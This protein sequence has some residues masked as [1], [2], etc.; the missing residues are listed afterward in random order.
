MGS[1]IG[2]SSC[3]F[4]QDK[5]EGSMSCG[6]VEIVSTWLIKSHCLVASPRLLTPSDSGIKFNFCR[7]PLGQLH[8]ADH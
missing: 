4:I 5:R 8:G 3:I 6:N 2:D 1:I 7:R